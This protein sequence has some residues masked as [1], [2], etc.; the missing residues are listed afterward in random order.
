MSLGARPWSIEKWTKYQCRG[1]CKILVCPT[2]HPWLMVGWSVSVLGGPSINN[3]LRP[4]N[5]LKKVKMSQSTSAFYLGISTN[6]HMVSVESYVQFHSEIFSA[7]PKEL[8]G[9]QTNHR[10][11][12]LCSPGG[13]MGRIWW[14]GDHISAALKYCKEIW[15][16]TSTYRASIHYR[17]W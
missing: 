8:I 12:D 5:R 14:P 7:K 9:R 1:E 16:V 11:W 10:W 17:K 3:L 6:G 15:H 4:W 13:F 2:E